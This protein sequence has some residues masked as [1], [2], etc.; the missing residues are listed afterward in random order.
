MKN[1][2]FTGQKN[3]LP[4]RSIVNN[5]IFRMNSIS[6]IL[7]RMH[8][9]GEWEMRQWHLKRLPAKFLKTGVNLRL[10]HILIFFDQIQQH[11]IYANRISCTEESIFAFYLL[12]HFITN[13]N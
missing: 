7:P 3:Y 12:L 10:F 2:Y 5:L 8:R 1:I 6:F 13:Q 11:L 9:S 4:K